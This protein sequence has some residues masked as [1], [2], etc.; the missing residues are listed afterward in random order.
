MKRG[1][2]ELYAGPVG[3]QSCELIAYFEGIQGI[4]K[5]KDGYNPATWM[6]EV[7]AASQEMI[8]GVDFTEIYKNSDLYR[9]NKAL[10]KELSTPR[11][12]SS[13]LSFPTHKIFVHDCYCIDLWI[14]VLGP[15]FQNG[16]SARPV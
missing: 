10:I 11:P 13:D 7:T 5:I 1:G 12:G 3:R 16:F 9:R 6:L 8:L 14:D 15:R 2:M 4:S